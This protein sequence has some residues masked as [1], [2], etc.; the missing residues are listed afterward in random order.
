MSSL[1]STLEKARPFLKQ[2]VAEAGEV[3]M[4]HFRQPH[5]TKRKIGTDIVTE[6]DYE[7]EALVANAIRERFPSHSLIAEE[8]TRGAPKSDFTWYLD[9]ID[10]TVT[11][12]AGIPVFC[13]AVSLVHLG[14]PVLG[15][16]LDPTRDQLF[17]AERGKGATCNG[18]P[19]RVSDT[20]D[21]ANSVIYI[22]SFGL[23]RPYLAPSVLE[24]LQNL[25]PQIR[26]IINLGSAGI[27]WAYVAS[28]YITA[29]ISY[30]V[31]QFTGPAGIL[32]IREA[33]GRATDFEGNDWMPGTRQVLTSN[34]R[35]HDQV[36]SLIRMPEDPENPL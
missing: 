8:G 16:I 31:D 6:A 24:T 12:A 11:Y 29:E 32:L 27:S 5:D 10:G 18:T 33:G 23:R 14:E 22:S 21:L 35:I 25:G 20:D 7:S 30:A 9:P 26:S 4:R 1:E 28:G 15:A 2:I 3:V 34:G 36:L 13:V 17:W 19:L